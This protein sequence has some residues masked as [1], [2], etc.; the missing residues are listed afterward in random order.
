VALVASERNYSVCL[1][2]ADQVLEVSAKSSEY[3]E[4]HESFSINYDET[5]VEIAF[6]P[7]FLVEPLRILQDEDVFFEFRDEMSPGVLRTLEDFVC[8]IMP[9]RLR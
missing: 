5:P 1:R 9:L 8:V 4:A 3:G 7:Q 6:N 2:I